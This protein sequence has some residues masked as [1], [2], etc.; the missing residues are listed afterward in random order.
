MAFVPKT[1]WVNDSPPGFEAD[2][3]IRMQ[4]GIADASADAASA[5]LAAA[6][7]TLD[8]S[9]ALTTAETLSSSG[10]IRGVSGRNYRLVSCALRNPG[11]TTWGVISDATH[12][13]TG[14]ASVE[15]M[16]DRVRVHYDFTGLR[17]SSLQ[18]TTDETITEHG[19]TAGASVG[20]SYADIYLYRAGEGIGD[21]VVYTAGAWSSFA[22][23]FTI[24]DYGVFGPGVLQLTHQSVGE[25][26][27]P[28]GGATARDPQWRVGVASMSQTL[29]QVQFMNLGAATM[30]GAAVNTMKAWV[31]RGGRTQKTPIDP[32]TVNMAGGNLWVTGLIEV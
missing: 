19:I 15:T 2:E 9:T 21:Y 23:V 29:T 6:Q 20:V 24:L 17:V 31:W 22:G 4:I 26:T 25:S 32:A 13:S 18:A 1:D 5:Q 8:A 27:N 14:V 7:A 12:T 28:I 30:A 3:M 16:A 11:G 10:L